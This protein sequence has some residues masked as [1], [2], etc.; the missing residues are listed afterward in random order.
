MTTQVVGDARAAT[1][2]TQPVAA[3]LSQQWTF[4]QTAANWQLTSRPRGPRSR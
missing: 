3:I 4:S 1:T 2:I